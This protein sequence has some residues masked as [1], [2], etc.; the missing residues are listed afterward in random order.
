VTDLR[1]PFDEAIGTI[2]RLLVEVVGEDYLLDVEIG[3][4][5]SFADDIE[6]ES[7]DLV[8]LTEQLEITYGQEVDFAG[9]IA[10]MELDDIIALTVGDLARFVV[11]SVRSEP[12]P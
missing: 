1:A 11:R 10:D 8:A 7:I 2:G 5:T 3:P 9:W 6:L 4:E 12:A